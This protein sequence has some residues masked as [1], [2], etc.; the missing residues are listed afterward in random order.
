MTA[1]IVIMNKKAVALAA[2]SAGT[3]TGPLGKKINNSQNKLFMLSKYEPIG[4]M[5]YNSSDFMGIPW[6]TIIKEYRKEL[7]DTNF[8]NLK[9]YVDGF[10][11]FVEKKYSGTINEQK[12]YFRKLIRRR[13]KIIEQ[14]VNLKDEKFTL[15]KFFECLNLILRLIWRI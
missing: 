11:N 2:D 8:D 7:G 13:F 9:G 4:I 5:V 12:N 3:V 1:E 14:T 15:K 6:E 10:F